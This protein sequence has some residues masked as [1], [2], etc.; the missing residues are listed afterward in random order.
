MG[1]R[2]WTTLFSAMGMLLL[3]LDG[4]T[5]LAGAR[6]GV[7]MCLYTVIPALFPFFVLSGI[8]TASL[9]G[10]RFAVLGALGRF[11]RIPAGAEGVFLIGLLGGY[12]SGARSVHQL[13]QEK[14]LSNLQAKRMLGFC[15]NAGPSFLFGICGSLFPSP[16]VGW[17]LWLIHIASSLFAARVLP[18]VDENDP[19][20]LTEKGVSMVQALKNALGAIA[21]VCG[22]IIVFRILLAFLD[23]WVFATKSGL[24]RLAFTGILELTNGCLWL[25]NLENTGLRLL[26]CGVFLA[27]GGLCVLLQTVSVTGNLGLGLY[28]PGKLLQTLMSGFLCLVAQCF[29]LPSADRAPHC[30]LLLLVFSGVMAVVTIFIR[31]KTKFQ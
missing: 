3:I 15:S 16:L 2:G 11:C 20:R 4:S 13:W 14:Q 1:K 10:A 24:L 8:L 9:T 6:E 30:P 17:L 27:F 18:E 29:L 7:Q 5:A 21:S 31:K 12:P 25:A 19:V 26:L 22:W 28:L 23:K